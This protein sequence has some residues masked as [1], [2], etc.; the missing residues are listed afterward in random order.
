MSC[1]DK[2]AGVACVLQAGSVGTKSALQDGQIQAEVSGCRRF[3]TY[4]MGSPD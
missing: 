4:Q 1:A 2:A 3:L